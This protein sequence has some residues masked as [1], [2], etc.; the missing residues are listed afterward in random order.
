MALFQIVNPLDAQLYKRGS[1]L[2]GRTFKRNSYCRRISGQFL[3]GTNVTIPIELLARRLPIKV[4]VCASFCTPCLLVRTNHCL[5]HFT[6]Q[7][8]HSRRLDR[9]VDF[10]KDWAQLYIWC[11][12]Q[13]PQ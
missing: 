11:T 2:L 10:E 6:V 7:S 3:K 13:I 12:K 1:K 5:Y 9:D 4:S 8:G